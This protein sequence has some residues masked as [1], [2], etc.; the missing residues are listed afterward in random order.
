LVYWL[1]WPSQ[2]WHERSPHAPPTFPSWRRVAHNVDQCQHSPTQYIDKDGNFQ[3]LNS[4]GAVLMKC[5]ALL[6]RT[7]G[8]ERRRVSADCDILVLPEDIPAAV[9]VLRDGRFLPLATPGR[10]SARR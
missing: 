1:G 10:I 4:I 5:A 9:G 3:G 2:R 6:A 8:L 7:P